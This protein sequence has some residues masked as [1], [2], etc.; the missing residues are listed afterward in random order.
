MKYI[1]WMT[2]FQPESDAKI[3]IQFCGTKGRSHLLG[4]YTKLK[5]EPQPHFIFETNQP[6]GD[7]ALMNYWIELGGTDIVFGI[8]IYVYEFPE[9]EDAK[10]WSFSSIYF[11]VDGDYNRVTSSKKREAFDGE[12]PSKIPNLDYCGFPSNEEP[13]W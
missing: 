2:P 13:P 7:I 3:W 6:I 10:A 5:K 11:Y 4:P 9:S 1:V 12:D 8:A